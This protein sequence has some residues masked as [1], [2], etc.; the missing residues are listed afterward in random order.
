M[1]SVFIYSRSWGKIIR[2]DDFFMILISED[3]WIGLIRILDIDISKMIQDNLRYMRTN[4]LLKI[5]PRS[6]LQDV[7][8]G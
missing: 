3:F 2:N 7:R 8:L 6:C 4:S 1:M 5:L